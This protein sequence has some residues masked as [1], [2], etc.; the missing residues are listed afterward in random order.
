M[1]S[2]EDS[3]RGSSAAY[4]PSTQL[5]IRSGTISAVHGG[6]FAILGDTIQFPEDVSKHISDLEL[7]ALPAK[8]Q[9]FMKSE[10]QKWSGLLREI[11]GLQ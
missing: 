9:D 5:D 7:M 6:V 2:R 11:G 1:A 4:Q 10:M 3:I 8:A